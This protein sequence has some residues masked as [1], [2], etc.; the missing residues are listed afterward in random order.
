MSDTKLT[1]DQINL[2]RA[3]NAMIGAIRTG[4]AM[5]VG[6]ICMTGG[7]IVA[8]FDEQDIA[9]SGYVLL[10]L[11]ALLLV[12]TAF[13]PDGSLPVENLPEDVSEN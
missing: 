12:M 4:S 3:T 10:F 8:S 2:N 7:L 11:G 13:I 5:V 1:A 6:F 9:I